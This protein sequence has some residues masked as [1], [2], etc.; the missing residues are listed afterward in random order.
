MA[1]HV[2]GHQWAYQLVYNP[3]LSDGLSLTDEEGTERLW[4]HFRKF[5]G[6]ARTLAVSTFL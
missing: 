2:Y 5:I 3:R 4:S 1:M 6:L